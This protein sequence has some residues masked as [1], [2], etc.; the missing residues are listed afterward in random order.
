MAYG[1]LGMDKSMSSLVEAQKVV[2]G[3]EDGLDVC[4]SLMSEEC[5]LYVGVV[6]SNR[7]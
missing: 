4:H 5:S 7:I 2:Q 6:F 3:D 1:I